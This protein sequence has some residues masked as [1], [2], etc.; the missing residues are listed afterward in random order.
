LSF[1][2]K[3]V[4]T[5]L[6]DETDNVTALCFIAESHNRVEVLR[7]VLE[8][9]FLSEAHGGGRF[10]LEPN[11]DRVIL[12]RNWDAI[13]TTVAQFSDELEAFVNSGMQAKDFIEAVVA[14]PEA[15]SAPVD[16]SAPVVDSLAQAY[17]T[18]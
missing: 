1:D 2:D 4:V 13:K 3:L 11:S 17:Q 15:T 18:I 5:F 10:A 14:T 16:G 9:N 8:Q 6:G 7:K 12:T